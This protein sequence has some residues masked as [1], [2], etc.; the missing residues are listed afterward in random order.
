MRE[1]SDMESNTEKHGVTPGEVVP[2]R[3]LLG[4]MLLE[5]NQPELAL[6]EY[7]LNLIDQI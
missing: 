2:A 7:E 5:L 6:V 3:E 4:D 1:A